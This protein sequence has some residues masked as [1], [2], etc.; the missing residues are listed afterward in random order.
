METQ[1]MSS[2]TSSFSEVC[3]LIDDLRTQF[4]DSPLQAGE[5]ESGFSEILELIQA[6]PH[7]R[8]KFVNLFIDMLR[9]RQPSPEWLIA[10]C[11]R[12]LRWPEVREAAEQLADSDNSLILSQAR[13][14]LRSYED[15]WLGQKLF[16][17]YAE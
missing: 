11:M 13:E 7:E 12:T 15:E 8:H 9:G 10:Y 17:R 3:R 6:A 14:V 1:E 2:H 5:M 4:P 16:D